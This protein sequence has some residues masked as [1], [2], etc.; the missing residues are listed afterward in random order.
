MRKDH[1]HSEARAR[2]RLA[3]LAAAVLSVALLAIGGGA[4]AATSSGANGDIAFVRGGSI[5]LVSTGTVLVGTA[6]D[7]TWSPDGTKLAFSAGG[8]I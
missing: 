7:P 2:R 5:Y 6:I 3:A 8:S 4:S 1:A